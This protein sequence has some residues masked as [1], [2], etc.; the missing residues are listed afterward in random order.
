MS[1]IFTIL[2][3]NHTKTFTDRAYRSA[4]TRSRV[5]WPARTHRVPTTFYG[6]SPPPSQDACPLLAEP[7]CLCSLRVTPRAVS[8][9]T[10]V[11]S[12]TATQRRPPRPPRRAA[13][14]C[15][16]RRCAHRCTPRP[17]RRCL[18]GRRC[19]LRACCRS[20]R[21][22][23][24]RRLRAW[25]SPSQWSLRSSC[26]GRPGQLEARDEPKTGNKAWLRRRLHAAIVR[27]HLSALNE[28]E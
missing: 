13:R 9:H 17:P 12:S 1:L 27:D 2:Y 5:R 28:G 19:L 7:S 24:P 23:W 21:T 18:K 3:W 14:S 6:R 10:P 20:R 25:P 8:S 4:H 22:C 11:C 15:A 16:R 26:L